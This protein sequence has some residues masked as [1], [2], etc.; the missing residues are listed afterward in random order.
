MRPEEGYMKS[1]KSLA[2][3]GGSLIQGVVVG[4]KLMFRDLLVPHCRWY[5]VRSKIHNT[6]IC[7]GAYCL[8]MLKLYDLFYIN[9]VVNINKPGINTNI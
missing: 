9:L 1:A 7:S 4:I 6:L 5:Y 3:L 2:S 8:I